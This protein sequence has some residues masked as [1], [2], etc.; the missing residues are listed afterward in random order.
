[1]HIIELF[2]SYMIL[3]IF[4]IK[5]FEN[6]IDEKPKYRIFQLLP[7]AVLNSI[8][9]IVLYEMSIISLSALFNYLYF[10]IIIK[11]QFSYSNK[12]A[13]INSIVIWLLSII[14]DM[15]VMLLTRLLE[16]NF[17]EQY[18]DIIKIVST[19]FIIIILWLLTKINYTANKIKKFLRKLEKLNYSTFAL[20]TVII[21]YIIIDVICVKNINQ[22]NVI[23]LLTFSTL[24]SF[25]F[26]TIFIYQQYLIFTL[27]ETN[28]FL[29]KNN[30]LYIKLINDYKIL[31]HN[32]TN[33]LLG[34]KSVSNKRSKELIDEIIKDY[35]KNYINTEN[36]N[37]IPNGINGIIYEKLQNKKIENLKVKVNNKI[38]QDILKLI[39]PRSYN[40][41]C[42]A[43][44]IAL[45]NAL[46]AT[47]KS[48]K[49][50]IYLE[51]IET[52]EDILIKII[53]TFLGEIDID[54]IGE[55]NYSTKG[56]NRG[57]GLY[58]LI[59]RNKIK[60]LNHLKNDLFITEIK[61]EK[62]TTK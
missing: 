12:K 54:R 5:V 42:E 2:I 4:I 61:I 17:F 18:I 60:I 8:I 6:I 13:I 57:V 21:A 30:E 47:N 22:N 51:F 43:L 32:L 7:I 9:N 46:E 62:K 35:N 3:Q 27:K 44:G 37:N 38:K 25:L 24:I 34:I 15:G 29:I 58:S 52:K 20:S 40:L 45:D 59:G 56:K 31:K 26:F 48:K 11:I 14:L 16:E 39:G 55:K 10:F 1:M 49:K 23:F 50:M 41:L 53:N 19:L 28:K 33:Q 36:M